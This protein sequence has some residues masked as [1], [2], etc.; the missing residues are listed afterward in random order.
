MKL[1]AW[2]ASV[3]GIFLCAGQNACM[4]E[5]TTGPVRVRVMSYNIHTGRGMDKQLDLERIATVINTSGADV[6][7]VQEVDRMTSRTL[8]VDQLAELTRLT[9]MFGRF[10]KGRDWEGGEYGQVLLSRWPILSFE[11]HPLPGPTDV[12]RR[13]ALAAEV[14]PDSMTSPVVVMATHLHHQEEAL[15]VPQAQEL[16][17]LADE[18]ATSGPVILMGDMNAVPGSE[19]MDMLLE[20]WTDGVGE[21]NTYPA[22]NPKKKIDWI[23]VPRGGAW[24]VV[25]GHV[26]EEAQAS[27]HRPVIV[28]LELGPGI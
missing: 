7:A 27:D 21:G 3:L 9:G 19:T 22:D 18:N 23:L 8:R 26:I 4:A 12:E 1:T 11:V 17:R 2:V 15:R 25:D 24:K 5:D 16:Q 28:E 20:K 6:V 14:Q 13:I 10:G